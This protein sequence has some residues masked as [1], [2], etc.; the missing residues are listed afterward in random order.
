VELA[1]R[2]VCAAPY[3]AGRDLHIVPVFLAVNL[4]SLAP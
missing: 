2:F 3:G 1:V 4:S